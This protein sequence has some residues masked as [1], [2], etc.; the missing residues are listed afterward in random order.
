MHH[1]HIYILLKYVLFLSLVTKVWSNGGDSRSPV[2]ARVGSNPT[3]GIIINRFKNLIQKL[4]YLS[5][6]NLSLWLNWIERPTSNRE[7]AGSSPAKD[8]ILLN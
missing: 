1:Y 8:Y 7:A 4:T 5:I 6:F 2:F 3:S